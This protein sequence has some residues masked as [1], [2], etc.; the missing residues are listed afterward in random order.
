MNKNKNLAKILCTSMVI[1]NI[2]PAFATVTNETNTYDDTTENVSKE[3]EVLYQKAGNYFVTIPKTI[4][5]GADKQSPYSVK[6]EGDIPS[7]KQVYVSPID[8]IKDTEVFDFYMHDTNT[9]NPKADVVATVTQNKFY[10]NFSEVANGYAE[11][12]NQVTAEDLT[13]GTWKGTFDFEINMKA[14]NGDESHTHSYTETIIKEP[15]CTEN[16]EKKL[17]CSCGDTKTETIPATG[18]NIID[19]SC[20]DCDV[21]VKTVD[22]LMAGGDISFDMGTVLAVDKTDTLKVNDIVIPE[23]NFTFDKEGDYKVTVETTNSDG[24]PIIININIT[25]IIN[26]GSEHTHS[27]T[28]TIIKEATCTESGEKKLTCSC[29]NSKTES[30]PSTGHNYGADDKCTNCGELNPNHKHNY[31]ETIIKEATCT[32]DGEKNLTC[33]CG[34][35][36]T[37][38]IPSTGHDYD[39]G[40]CKNCGEAES[41]EHSYVSKTFNVNWIRDSDGPSG[42]KW[43]YESGTIES[44]RY[45]SN[46][47]TG[48]PINNSPMGGINAA[49]TTW[50]ITVPVSCTTQ[51]GFKPYTTSGSD[52]RTFIYL[53]G[54][55]VWKNNESAANALQYKYKTVTLHKGDNYVKAIGYEAD[56][57][58]LFRVTGEYQECDIC[59]SFPVLAEDWDYELNEEDKTITLKQYIGS[60]LDVT[61]GSNYLVNGTSYKTKIATNN[62]FWAPQYMF[63][64]N[65]NIKTVTFQPNVVFSDAGGA[66]SM[67]YGCTSLSSIDFSGLDTSNVTNM[68]SMF[69]N[70]N[71]LT[72][73]DF[74]G[75]DTSNVT[76]MDKMFQGCNVLTNIDLSGLDT[77]SV[78]NM[79]GIFYNCKSLT[80]IDLSSLDTSSVTSMGNMFSYCTSLTSID[81]SGLD[82][83]NV[84]SMNAMFSDCTSLTSIDLRGLETSNVIYMQ[85]M[86]KNCSSIKTIYVTK[87]SWSVE[88]ADTTN[89]F[90]NCG[91]S[92]VTY[93]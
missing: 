86:F 3:T 21:I 62:N 56:Y 81:L 28:E 14:V 52:P 68:G 4:S 30:I 53:N 29:G 83:S 82:T 9:A 44:V 43:I 1:G 31:I 33:S 49:I 11:T 16:G 5:L 80:D 23:Q 87:D 10:W 17:T 57:I 41:C 90:A 67:F 72:N 37:E 61:V 65:K 32:E 63:F 54:K 22:D 73:I 71:S 59:N 88:Q 48:I 39:N 40:T 69:Q 74:S 64:N 89:M 46:E 24:T 25:V 42:Y 45:K 55:E 84:T 38:S 60:D 51:I 27:Y 66:V 8:G 12:E 35:S 47:P 91:T 15:T 18:H 58:E 26:Q 50:K 19:G 70:C 7:D 78:T 85:N 34:D 75:L 20:T 93:K 79:N 6:V 77:S 76:S 92:T 13:S 36:K 2:T